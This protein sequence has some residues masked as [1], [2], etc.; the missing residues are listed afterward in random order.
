[1]KHKNVTG[2]NAEQSQSL[3][4]RAFK[5]LQDDKGDHTE[6]I[7]ILSNL[8]MIDRNGLLNIHTEFHKEY[9]NW[10]ADNTKTRYGHKYD[11]RRLK[12]GR[13]LRSKDPIHALKS[14]MRTEEEVQDL[15]INKRRSQQ[16]GLTV[17]RA[18]NISRTNATLPFQML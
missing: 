14:R 15:L 9:R 2:A 6:V 13:V 1:M 11:A 3:L 17:K 4:E 8:M 5:D 18:G 7:W 12:A 10:M 16:A